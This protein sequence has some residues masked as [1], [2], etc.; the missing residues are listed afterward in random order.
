MIHNRLG[1]RFGVE[2]FG[3]VLIVDVVPNPHKFPSIVAACEKD[4]SHTENFRSRDP[5]EIRGVCFKDEFVDANWDGANEKRVEL[6]VVLGSR[7]WL[8][9]RSLGKAVL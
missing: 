2:L 9:D 6:L 4:D 8:S 5:L 7:V 3:V 1:R